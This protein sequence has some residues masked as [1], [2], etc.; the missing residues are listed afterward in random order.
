M[1]F[2]DVL[3]SKL[4]NLANLNFNT[5][6]R[7]KIGLDL[8]KIMQMVS[9]LESIDTAH[10]EPLIYLNE[11]GNKLRKDQVANQLDKI[12]ALV[13]APAH[14]DNFITIPKVIDL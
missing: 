10:V 12:Q 2:D 4:E 13:N 8:E 3:I 7:R 6:E 14:N 5:H 11:Q 9:K 1:Q